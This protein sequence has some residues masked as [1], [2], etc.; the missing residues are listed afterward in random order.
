MN[1]II[2][3]STRPRSIWSS[4]KNTV[5]RFWKGRSRGESSWLRD[6]REGNVGSSAGRS[7]LSLKYFPGG[8]NSDN[9]EGGFVGSYRSDPISHLNPAKYGHDHRFSLAA[10]ISAEKL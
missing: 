9:S 3:S 5:I 4:W 8:Y 2:N 6:L 1:G 7:A 10:A